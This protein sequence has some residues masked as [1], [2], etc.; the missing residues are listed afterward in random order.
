[1]AKHLQVAF[2]S[3]SFR[4]P[5]TSAIHR[6]PRSSPP[7]SWRSTIFLALY[8]RRQICPIISS[9]TDKLFKRVCGIIKDC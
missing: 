1:M 8:L 9:H 4:M 7:C 2:V 5:L 3:V 6:P